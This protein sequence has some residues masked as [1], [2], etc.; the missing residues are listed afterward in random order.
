MEMR[1]QFT[2]MFILSEDVVYDSGDAVLQAGVIS[3]EQMAG[4]TGNMQ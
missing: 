3:A 2:W 1:T 4:T